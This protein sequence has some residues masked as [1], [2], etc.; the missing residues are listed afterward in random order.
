MLRRWG[1]SGEPVVQQGMLGGPEEEARRWRQWRRRA[2]FH[3]G[4]S[5]TTYCWPRMSRERRWY[6][7][8]SVSQE[9]ARW[10]SACA[11]RTRGRSCTRRVALALRGSRRG[12]DAQEEMARR[13]AHGIHGP[14]RRR[15]SVRTQE[16]HADDAWH[17]V[18]SRAAGARARRRRLTGPA[19]FHLPCF[20]IA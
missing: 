4:L 16:E 15:R 3:V 9:A 13:R 19:R 11:G 1:G 6:G 7:G 20:E 12:R 18:P 14:P 10:C 17:A 8:G 2:L 5:T